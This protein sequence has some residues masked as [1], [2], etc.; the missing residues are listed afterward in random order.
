MFANMP[1]SI[2]VTLIGS[3]VLIGLIIWIGFYR[4]SRS[5]GS[6]RTALSMSVAIFLAAWL[7]LAIGLGLN[8]FFGRYAVPRV[9]GIA[10]AFLPLIIGY[11]LASVST[12]L[13][14]TIDATPPQWMIGVQTYRILGTVFLVLFAQGGLPGVFALPAGIGDFL[15][16]ITAPLV[17]YLTITKHPWSRGLALLWNMIGITDLVLA[18]ALGF[19]SSPG[20]FHLLSLNNPNVLITSFPLVLI[21]AFA[22]PL[23]ML[24]HLLSLRWLVNSKPPRL[25]NNQ[26]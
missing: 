5:S 7:G 10:F 25:I 4:T 23:S 20:P 8:G 22:V 11:I 3:N 19:L 21:P 1:D 18:V 26:T 6:H 14:K 9:P 24:L 12:S 13:R 15:V 17:A 2:S 16:G